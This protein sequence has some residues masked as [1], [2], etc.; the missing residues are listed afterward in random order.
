VSGPL[1]LVG[2]A[3]AVSGEA[4]AA[5]RKLVRALPQTFRAD[6]DDIW[7]LLAGT[8]RRLHARHRVATRRRRGG[9]AAFTH[10]GDRPHRGQ[11]RAGAPVLSALVRQQ[12]SAC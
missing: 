7:Y 1:L 6:K 10:L 9:A 11:V 8:E 2:P 3:A 4:K 5:L 12:R